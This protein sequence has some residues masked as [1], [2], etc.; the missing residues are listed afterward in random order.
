M[1]EM[2]KSEP[3]KFQSCLD[4]GVL[5][6]FLMGISQFM[7]PSMLRLFRTHDADQVLNGVVELNETGQIYWNHQPMTMDHIGEKVV[8]VNGPI[9]LV[10]RSG[11]PDSLMM[12][13]MRVLTDSGASNIE[14]RYDD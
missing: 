14:F 12:Q 11:V 2:T 8:D 10:A 7:D 6:V 5:C 9:T 13:V 1:S 4:M 3:G